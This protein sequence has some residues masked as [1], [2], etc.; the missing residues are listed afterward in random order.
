MVPIFSQEVKTSSINYIELSEKI[1]SELSVSS[2]KEKNYNI[3]K[4]SLSSS[5]SNTFPSNILIK[6]NNANTEKNTE[7]TERNNV[8]FCFNQ[9]DY[10]ENSESIKQFVSYLKLALLPYNTYVLFTPDQTNMILEKTEH[11]ELSGLDCFLKDFYENDFTLAISFTLDKSLTKDRHIDIIPGGSKEVSPPWLMKDIINSCYNS[12]Y[13]FHIP[14]NYVFLYRN[15][16]ITHETAT[17]KF[18]KN[19]IPA[20]GLSLKDFPS[21]Y[22]LQSIC[23][24]LKESRP[25]LWEKHYAYIQFFTHPLFINEFSMVIL[26]I[27]FVS[28]C[29]AI[30][31]FMIFKKNETN[32]KKVF[33]LKDTWYFSIILLFATFIFLTLFQWIFTSFSNLGALCFLGKTIFTFIAVFSLLIIQ[34]SFRF[35][36]SARASA[37]YLII[38]AC[39]N[40]ILFS[41]I[42]ITLIFI[43]FE[44]FLLAYFCKNAK[45]KWLEHTLT[46]MLV[47]PFTPLIYSILRYADQTKLYAVAN[48]NALGNIVTGL[49]LFPIIIQWSRLAKKQKIFQENKNTSRKII[50]KKSIFII[51]GTTFILV[52]FFMMIWVVARKEKLFEKQETKNEIT[53][54]ELID[55]ID[56]S[57]SI[58]PSTFANFTIWHLI[59]QSKENILRYEVSVENKESVPVYGSNF[60]YTFDNKNKIFFSIPEH[61]GKKL[62]I[63][64]RSEDEKNST[65][66]IKC[67]AARHDETISISTMELKLEG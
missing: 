28:V 26:Y 43:F 48:T 62:D 32:D 14:S 57:A 16:L 41:S 17:S 50:L 58:K 34:V 67:Y 19:E 54:I 27:A 66:R 35:K 46:F 23:E 6:I 45:R 12:S 15:N 53:K 21:P 39:L 2:Y 33:K 13:D 8:L 52:S 59:L 65:I 63:S 37:Y 47:L 38:Y 24:S 60:D 31:S 64:F 44:E 29:L 7:E 18:L 55:E 11:N 51:S 61:P 56:F 9:S 4:L 10:I 1:Y 36:I 25:T 22:L 5:E 30:L 3:E 40:L 49:V 20:V 42:D